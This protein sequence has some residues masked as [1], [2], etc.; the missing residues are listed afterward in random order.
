MVGI[1]V[2]VVL[3]VASVF[4]AVD[5]SWEHR[6]EVPRMED[7]IQHERCMRGQYVRGWGEGLDGC[8]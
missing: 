3:G 5:R 8:P 2:V 1:A 6:L 7:A 4:S